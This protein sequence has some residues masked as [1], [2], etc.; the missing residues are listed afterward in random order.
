[1][2]KC[3]AVFCLQKQ[4]CHVYKWLEI[5]SLDYEEE[6]DILLSASRPSFMRNYHW[7]LLTL[8]NLR[9]KIG[10]LL[11]QWLGSSLP[12][13]QN[14]PAKTSLGK[15]TGEAYWLSKWSKKYIKNLTIL[16]GA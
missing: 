13:P 12:S 3:S 10:R 15:E 4:Q 6:V 8:L 2:L 7:E 11:L 14:I 1:M 16:I 5:K 9:Q